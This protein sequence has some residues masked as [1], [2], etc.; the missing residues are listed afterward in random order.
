[1]LDIPPSFLK[2][3][4]LE[5]QQGT[6]SLVLRGGGHAPIHGQ[7]REKGFNSRLL[8]FDISESR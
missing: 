2:H 7:V 6:E 1:V 5:K 3:L 4:S 8:C